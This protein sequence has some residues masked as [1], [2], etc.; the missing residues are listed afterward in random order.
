[1]S[2]IGTQTFLY[3]SAFTQGNDLP[4]NQQTLFGY[5]CALGACPGD[6]GLAVSWLPREHLEYSTLTSHRQA[7]ILQDMRKKQTNATTIR[8]EQADREAIAQIR[9][10]Y[11]CP[12]DSAAIKLAVRMVARQEVVPTSPA[13]NKERPFYPHS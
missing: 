3:A 10:L 12:S 6:F 11:G 8:L 5:L 2:S 9:K 13:P 4:W 1:M 7:T